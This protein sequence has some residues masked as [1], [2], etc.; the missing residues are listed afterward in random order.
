MESTIAED[1]H[2]AAVES[3]QPP[4]QTDDP[5]TLISDEASAWFLSERGISRRTLTEAGVISRGWRFKDRSGLRG[6]ERDAVAFPYKVKGQ[7]Y[8]QKLRSYPDK[9]FSQAGSAGT[10]WLQDQVKPGEDLIIVE[11]ELDAL[12][13]RE[14]G[15]WSVIS[16]PNGAPTEVSDRAVNPEQDRKFRF[17]WL[18]KETLDKAK[19]IILAGDGDSP[20]S[21]LMEEIAR[22]IGKFRCWK[23]DWPEECKDANDVLKIHGKDYLLDLVQNPIPWPVAGV[24]DVD[25]YHDQLMAMFDGGLSR[26]LDVGLGD[27]LFE[28]FSVVPGHLVVI[29]GEPGSGKST[30]WNQV[31]VNLAKAHDWIFAVYSSEATP[32]VHIAMLAQ[33]YAAKPFFADPGEERMTREEF[34]EA[35]KWVKDHFIFLDTDNNPSYKELLDLL[36]VAVM[37]YG[38]RGYLVDPANYLRRDNKEGGPEWVGEM[39]EEFRKFG[40]SH[41]CVATVIAHPKKPPEGEAKKPPTG[42]S[43]SGSADWFNRADF[44]ITVYRPA[45]ERHRSFVI[46]WKTRFNWTGKE[47]KCELFYDGRTTRFSGE[48]FVRAPIYSMN[49]EVLDDDAFKM[50]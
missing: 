25:H 9:L 11:G 39:L 40:I 32:P 33:A 10:F 15:H 44:G 7:V 18:G 48:P 31:M 42:Y 5:D 35:K 49:F 37:R 29:T 1:R 22:R 14:A 47:G 41:D 13:L 24:Y 38:I 2:L 45:D 50:H 23:I 20:G 28:L 43:I 30:L 26:G 4:S 19:R 12:A 46:N 6:D 36:Q 17:V 3:F 8:A 27:D 34:L 16:A 21:A